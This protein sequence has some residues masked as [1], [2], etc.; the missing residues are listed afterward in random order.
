MKMTQIE[1]ELEEKVDSID[2]EVGDIKKDLSVFG[3]EQGVVEL[4][5][6]DSGDVKVRNLK[7]ER[8]KR[9]EKNKLSQDNMGNRNIYNVNYNIIFSS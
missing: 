3:S 7:N 5:I 4:E 8:K 9:K 2:K 6:G 1:K